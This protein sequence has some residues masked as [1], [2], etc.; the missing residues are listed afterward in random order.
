MKTYNIENIMIM[1]QILVTSDLRGWLRNENGGKSS[2]APTK[3][4][5]GGGEGLSHSDGGGGGAL[6][7]LNVAF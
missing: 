5:R 6:K 1:H 7:H 2:F 3:K 4:K